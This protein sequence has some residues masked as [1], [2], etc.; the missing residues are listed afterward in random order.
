VFDELTVSAEV[1]VRDVWEAVAHPR[2]KAHLRL[3]C[4]QANTGV[5]Q[6]LSEE[7]EE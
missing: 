4:W 7:K 5:Q 3:V 2:I 6:L 1:Y